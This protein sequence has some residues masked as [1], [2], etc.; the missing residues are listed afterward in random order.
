M[1]GEFLTTDCTD[2]TEEEKGVGEFAW[3]LGW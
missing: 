3:C 1:N 2:Y